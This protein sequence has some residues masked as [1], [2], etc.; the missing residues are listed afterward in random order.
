MVAILETLLLRTIHS[1]TL[2]KIPST[3]PSLSRQLELSPMIIEPSINFLES[4][5]SLIKQSDNR[6]ILSPFGKKQITLVMTGGTFDILHVGH[7][8]T[9]QQAKLLGDLLAVVV[10]TDKTVEKRKNRPPTNPQKERVQIVRH[11]REVDAVILGDETDF[12]NSVDY[13][14]PDI[15]ALGYDQSHDEKN[16]YKTLSARGHGHVKIVRL[17]QYIAGKS[18]SKIMQDIIKH[19]YRT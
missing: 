2:N 1:N 15:I 14:Q 17:K 11:I 19:S 5:G 9:F 13:I 16:L 4:K 18:T 8:F 12:M 6:Y 7:I 3:I 10:A